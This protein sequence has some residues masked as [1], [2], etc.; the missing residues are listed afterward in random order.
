MS[1]QEFDISGSQQQELQQD[2]NADAREQYQE[3]SRE[4][5]RGE[6]RYE[7]YTPLLDAPYSVEEKILPERIAEYTSN[8]TNRAGLLPAIILIAAL[9]LMGLGGL[10][11]L[12]LSHSGQFASP[13]EPISPAY[14]CAHTHFECHFNGPFHDDDGQGFP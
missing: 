5:S 8:T 9:G 10:L 1:M 12:S 3:E 14:R 7:P 4:G 13:A 11:G 6:L 2:F